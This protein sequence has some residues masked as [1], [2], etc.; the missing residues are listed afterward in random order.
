MLSVFSDQFTFE[1]VAGKYKKELNDLFVREYISYGRLISYDKEIISQ[2]IKY[3]FWTCWGKYDFYRGEKKFWPWAKREIDKFVKHIVGVIVSNSKLKEERLNMINSLKIDLELS[4]PE[5]LLE[6]ID[7]IVKENF[8][9]IWYETFKLYLEGKTQIQVV[10]EINKKYK[11]HRH[12]SNFRRKE[13]ED[14]VSKIKI[15]VYKKLGIN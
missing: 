12:I 9:E 1:K 11:I 4:L 15:Y 2:A 14:I 8:T 7:Q 10:K 13:V 3:S 6:E 5:N